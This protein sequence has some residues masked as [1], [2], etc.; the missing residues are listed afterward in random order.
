MGRSLP[1]P[2][3]VSLVLAS[4]TTNVKCVYIKGMT[5]TGDHGGDSNDEVVA[6]LFAYSHAAAFNGSWRN[7]HDENCLAGEVQQVLLHFLFYLI[8]FR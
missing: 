6:T 7:E 3:L 5:Q 4:R 2:A 8:S 1:T